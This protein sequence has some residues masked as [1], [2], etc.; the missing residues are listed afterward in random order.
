M[1][2]LVLP[3][4]KSL[5]YNLCGVNQTESELVISLTSS[6]SILDIEAI[7]V[8]EADTNALLHD[9]GNGVVYANYKVFSNLSKDKTGVYTIV[10]QKDSLVSQINALSD[11]LKTLQSRIV[12]DEIA[13]C[14]VYETIPTTTEQEA[15]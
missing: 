5:I 6:T 3:S 14:E 4:G 15:V 7:T 11:T 13:L 1:K 12:A 9:V 10:Y 2:T 8:D